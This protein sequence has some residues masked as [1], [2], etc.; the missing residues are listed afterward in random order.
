MGE[1]KKKTPCICGAVL[2]VIIIVLALLA[3][4]EV[5][6][7]WPIWVVVIAAAILGIA[8]LTGCCCC[9]SLCKP[10]EGEESGSCCQPPKDIADGLPRAQQRNGVQ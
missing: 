1:A 7:G 4:Y 8:S 9:A 5:V 3:H 10:K 6:K 2:A